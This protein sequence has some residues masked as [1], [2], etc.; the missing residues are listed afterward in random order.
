MG[1][2]AKPL[3]PEELGTELKAL[4]EIRELVGIAARDL[5]GRRPCR[6]TAIARTELE[7]AEMWIQKAERRIGGELM[8]SRQRKFDEEG[9]ED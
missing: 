9:T 2:D 8:A 4:K 5:A 6:E 3:T 1:F 7:T